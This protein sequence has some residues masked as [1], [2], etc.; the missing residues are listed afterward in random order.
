MAGALFLAFIFNSLLFVALSRFFTF[1]TVLAALV[2]LAAPS[3]QAQRKSKTAPAADGRPARLQP[4]FG[5]LS[6]AEAT[7][8]LGA[9]QLEA[10]AASFAS[11]AE[12]SAFLANKGYE[13]LG[14]NQPDTAAYRFNL[15]WLLNPQNADAYRGL[16]IVASAQ[17]QPDAAIALLT[18]GLALAPTHSLLLSDLGSSHLIRYSQTNK[19]KDLNAGVGFLERATAADPGN[20]LAWQQLARGYYHQEKYPQAWEAVHKGRTLSM[21]SIDFGLIGELLAK[22]PDPQGTFK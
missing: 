13:Y 22:Q 18:Q 8:L 16:G 5:G 7:R 10:I 2:S 12:A 11:R 20:A 21:N 19:K 17:P 3:A 14:E 4:L 6:A 9:G 15:A 1:F